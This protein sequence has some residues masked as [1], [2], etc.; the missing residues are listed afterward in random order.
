MSINVF[1]CVI[2]WFI[3][4]ET[5]ILGPH[6]E[7][8][9]T[10]LPQWFL[11]CPQPG[12]L[13]GAGGRWS[14]CHNKT[15]LGQP[16]LFE[17]YGFSTASESQPPLRRYKPDTM[18]KIIKNIGKIVSHFLWPPA[19]LDSFTNVPEAIPL[20]FW[21]ACDKRFPLPGPAFMLHDEIYA[22]GSLDNSGCK[23][24]YYSICH[25]YLPLLRGSPYESPFVSRCLKQPQK[26]PHAVKRRR[27]NRCDK[28]FMKCLTMRA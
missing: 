24:L 25:H 5:N 17:L 3:F 27:R 9:V 8:K 14:I 28:I 6:W 20:N 11:I 4:F 2:K 26:I 1:Y 23:R 15:G 13:P 18:P 22:S 16:G 10:R 7:C 21:N 12:S 19:D